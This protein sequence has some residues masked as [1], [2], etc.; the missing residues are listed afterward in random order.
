MLAT[1]LRTITIPCNNSFIDEIVSVDHNVAVVDNTKDII[2]CG[3]STLAGTQGS[4]W[5]DVNTVF[6]FKITLK[7]NKKLSYET[8][9]SY[10]QFS[11]L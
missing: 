3:A 10:S 6:G 11:Y 8:K 2:K 5:Q 7:S 4:T 1:K 9:V